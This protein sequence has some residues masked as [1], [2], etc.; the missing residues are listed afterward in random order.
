MTKS[1]I[2]VPSHQLDPITHT[3]RELHKLSYFIAV[4]RSL[5]TILENKYCRKLQPL[6]LEAKQMPFAHYFLNSI[7]KRLVSHMILVFLFS[8]EKEDF[9]HPSSL[10]SLGYSDFFLLHALAVELNADETKL[11]AALGSHL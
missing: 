3:H 7:D 11:G 5:T 4:T 2:K 9:F 6:L 1:L 10:I 8:S